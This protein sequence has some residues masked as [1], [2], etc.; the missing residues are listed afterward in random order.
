MIYSWAYIRISLLLLSLIPLQ[1]PSKDKFGSYFLPMN[2][3]CLPNTLA[4]IDISEIS[5]FFGL[6][7]GNAF[8]KTIRI[9]CKLQRLNFYLCQRSLFCP[10]FLNDALH[11]VLVTQA[12]D[13]SPPELHASKKFDLVRLICFLI[14]SQA[15]QWLLK[16]VNG[17]N[18]RPMQWMLYS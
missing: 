9:P 6:R 2:L 3:P 14:L 10:T 15:M 1:L 16:G 18:I 17:W 8:L 7:A 4:L 5:K 11:L 13:N 12:R